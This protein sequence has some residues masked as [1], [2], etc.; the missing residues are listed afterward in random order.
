MRPERL[1]SD[2]EGYRDWPQ[3]ENEAILMGFFCARFTANVLKFLTILL[4]D[5]LTRFSM[6]E[7]TGRTFH[8][9]NVSAVFA[10]INTG[11]GE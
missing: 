5:Q 2:E 10:Q 4:T 7:Q 6:V 1:T 9:L 8:T 3:V 11:Q